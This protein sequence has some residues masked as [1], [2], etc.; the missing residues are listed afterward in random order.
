MKIP[1]AKIIFAAFLSVSVFQSLEATASGQSINADD[2]TDKAEQFIDLLSQNEFEQATTDFDKAMSDAMPPKTL[3]STWKTLERVRGK[4]Q[5][6]GPSRIEKAGKY[7][8]V[9]V[10]CQFRKRP[11][12]A[13][14]VFDGE[15]KIA[16]LQFVEG[17]QAQ[18]SPPDYADQSAFTEDEVTIGDK[19]WVLPA[20]ISIPKGDGS[21]PAIILVHGSGPNDR[22]ESAGANKPFKDLAW[23]LAS[24]GLVVLRYDK[25]TLV[26]GQRLAKDN[27]MTVKEET[28]DDAIAAIQSLKSHA[29]VDPKK[30]IVVGHSL[31]GYLMPRIAQADEQGAA[32]GFVL[33]AGNT[34]PIHKLIWEQTNYMLNLDGSLS[35]ADRLNLMSLRPLVDRVDSSA[36]AEAKESSRLLGV[37]PAYWLDLRDYE[38]TKLASL[39]FDKPTLVLQGERDYQVTMEDFN[40]WKSALAK[41]DGVTFRSYPKL[42][43]LFIAGEGPGNPTEY[44]TPGHV[45][46]EV[47]TDIADW[48][49]VSDFN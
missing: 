9:F 14:V 17:K 26:H 45:A 43:H 8:F 11:M 34:R 36:L 10:S 46:V 39:E 42:N 18:Y 2:L 28:I 25:R 47:I 24:R 40:A 31:G 27:N 6:R 3:A 19:P 35:L 20:T 7:T 33:L 4:L 12:D 44:E 49:K 30:I 16:G 21:F 13:R 38:P 48:I 15:K 5:K 22:D 1:L 41:R 32:A 23:G 37:S 29:K